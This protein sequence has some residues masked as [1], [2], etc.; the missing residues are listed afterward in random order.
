MKH[1]NDK[2]IR[3]TQREVSQISKNSRI[4]DVNYNG[5]I[6]EYEDVADYLTQ[7][8]TLKGVRIA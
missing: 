8:I 3:N 7:P 5:S 4:V 2:F 6:E 1:S